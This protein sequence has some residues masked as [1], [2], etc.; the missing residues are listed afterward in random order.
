MAVGDLI[1]WRGK[2]ITEPPTHCP[3]G[4]RLGPHQTLVGHTACG[5]HGGGG[6]TIW[7]CL[8]CDAITYGPAV[9]THCNI[10]IGPAAVRLS[11]A[12]NEGDIPNWPAPP[13]PPF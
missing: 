4:H 5:G 11:T 6:H 9:N 8:T 1:Q 3:N 7:H 10:A 2:W 12:K 13:P